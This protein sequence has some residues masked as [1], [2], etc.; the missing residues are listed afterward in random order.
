MYLGRI[1]E[2]GAKREVYGASP[3]LH[4]RPARGGAARAPVGCRA[5]SVALRRGSAHPADPPSGCRFRTRC[6]HARER[7]AAEEPVC[8]TWAMAGSPHA[9]SLELSRL[10]ARR[11]SGCRTSA[12]TREPIDHSYPLVFIREASFVTLH[13]ET[14]G[15][16]AYFTIDNGT[17]NAFTPQC[18]RISTSTC[19][20]S[21]STAGARRHPGRRPGQTF[22]RG[23]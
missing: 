15:G 22:L 14:R 6:P 5:A 9:T 12:L 3:P 13:Y 11:A 21:T 19:A 17:V 7:C 8:A 4:P 23:R 18:T 1:V 16:I 2:I 20:P 10:T